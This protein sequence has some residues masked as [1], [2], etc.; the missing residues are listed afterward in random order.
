LG[1]LGLARLGGVAADAACKP[2][3]GPQSKCTKD[4]QCC[5]G[6]CA[7]GRCHCIPANVCCGDPNTCEA[8]CCTGSVIAN[9]PGC[10]DNGPI[11]NVG[12]PGQPCEA[13]TDC[14]VA[15]L[16]STCKGGTRCYPAGSHPT[17]G[18]CNACCSGKC[19]ADGDCTSIS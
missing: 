9:N 18:G 8:N 13:D 14:F 15:D 3:T 10:S 7:G 2:T 4:A 5:S 12:S 19:D 11:C 17:H 1:A 16:G 6:R